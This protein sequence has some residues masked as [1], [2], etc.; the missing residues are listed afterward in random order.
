MQKAR[1]LKNDEKFNVMP[2]LDQAETLAYQRDF[3]GV[4][5][6]A[7]GDIDIAS[8]R[9]KMQ[10]IGAM[11][12]AN[13]KTAAALAG[14]THR[15]VPQM[16]PATGYLEDRWQ[17][18]D[19]VTGKAI[20]GD[21]LGTFNEVAKLQA[22]GGGRAGKAVTP[23]QQQEFA[24]KVFRSKQQLTEIQ[25]IRALVNSPDVNAVGYIAGSAPAKFVAGTQ[26][27]LPWWMGGSDK[28]YNAQTRLN[29][30]VSGQ[31]MELTPLLKGPL[32]EKELAF[33]RNS[34]P[35]LQSTEQI[36]NDWLN[37]LEE[38][39]QSRIAAMETRQQ[40]ENETM[41]SEAADFIKR[42]G[43]T[44]AG[45]LSSVVITPAK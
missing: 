12:H 27:A 16:N 37:G 34:I 44:A 15:I 30:F 28:K 11:R 1:K 43:G 26:S 22:E 40:I 10:E 7:T 32:S 25:N 20:D 35:T 13:A 41:T 17:M 18:I 45:N 24:D 5:R 2:T 19:T 39:Y 14:M 21:F 42:L 36:W 8:I 9:A 38:L 4:P 29:Q 23:A 33:L 3:G 31:T 6:T